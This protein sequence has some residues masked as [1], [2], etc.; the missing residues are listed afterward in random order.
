VVALVLIS[1][2]LIVRLAMI[3]PAQPKDIFSI[4][5]SL[6]RLFR[7]SPSVEIRIATRD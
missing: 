5:G 6:A 4:I 3:S 7:S 1:G 2:M